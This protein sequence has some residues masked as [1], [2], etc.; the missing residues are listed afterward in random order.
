M[1]KIFIC[2]SLICS[3]FIYSCNQNKYS[4]YV[5][6]CMGDSITYGQDPMP[7]YG[8]I[9]EPYPVQLE[10]T[11]GFKKVIN[12]GISGSTVAEG[13]NSYEPMVNRI[14]I[15]DPSTNVIIFYGG[16]NDRARNLPLGKKGDKDT[17]SLYGAYYN[18][19]TFIKEN[20]KNAFTMF[21]TPLPAKLDGTMYYI[22]NVINPMKYTC[23]QF[24][25]PLLDLTFN[26]GFEEE[27]EAGKNDGIHPSQEY[28]T[29]VL[30]PKIANFIKTHL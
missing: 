7:P 4:S 1:K 10:K 28:V 13:T 6:S 18:I 16:G 12:Y 3:S 14:K 15:I 11:L 8:Q 25:I 26:S 27:I 5:V 29:N 23:E 17:T 24:N 20:F 30:T 9:A 21:M 22:S 2:F 19:C